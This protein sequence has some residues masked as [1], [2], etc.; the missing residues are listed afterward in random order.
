MSASAE[1]LAASER[2]RNPPDRIVPSRERAVGHH[3]RAVCTL[4]A[5]A[6]IA[7]LA[8]R[9]WTLV[10]PFP[11]GLD[12]AQWLALGRGL[13]A[14]AIGRSTE[15]AYA[16]LAPVLAA[17][18]ESI[19]GPLLAVRLLAAASGL[20]VSLAVWSIARGALG[21]VW[22]LAATAIIIPASALAEPTLYGGYPQQFALTAGII[23]LWAACRYLSESSA[24]SGARW[25]SAT[26]AA[27]PASPASGHRSATFYQHLLPTPLGISNNRRHI[28]VGIA[29][30][31]T[32][33]AHHVYFPIFVLAILTAVGLCLSD[34][35]RLQE[36]TRVIGSLALALTPAL[37]L[38][39]VV[40]VNFIRAGYAAPLDASARSVG[41]AWAYGT[42][43]S[44]QLWF[45][46]LATG[47]A[48]LA[49]TRRRDDPAWLLA[50][51][52]LTP[53]GLLFLL[54][55]QPRL[56]PPIVI[57]A[58][59]A[60]GLCAKWVA[61]MWSRAHAGVVLL[62][63]A[64]A[65]ALVVPADRATARFAE[66][67]RVVDDSLVRAAAAIESDGHPGAVAVRADHRGWP[68]GWWFEGLLDRPVIVGSNP[69]WLAFP[70]EREHARLA[71]SLFDGRLAAETFLR[72]AVSADVR[73]LVVAKWD[74]IGWERWLANPEFPL[75]TIYDDDRY[76]VLRVT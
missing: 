70:A 66:F 33:A 56:I 49:I 9:R 2:K 55:G 38:F 44:P 39:A 54:S 58:G 61:S 24:F 53:A 60:A 28:T 35:S 27:T 3:V 16:P 69:R 45:L 12:G 41:D 72:R 10:G 76:L 73:Y 15:G 51:S 48:G 11:P 36:S 68:I 8:I 31:F 59:I 46:I 23:A 71:E 26:V 42:R 32:A 29:A 52:L 40:A 34:R 21:P 30:L 75:T 19:A 37:A 47:V 67:Y 25:S 74:W 6:G 4:L 18:A 5:F 50:I 20:A 13:D 22:G 17:I 57:G 1:S 65:V 63:L 64:I 43:E 62:T 7:G 14:Q